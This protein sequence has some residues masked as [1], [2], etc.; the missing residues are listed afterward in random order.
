[1]PCYHPLKGYRA[2]TL[3]P[4]G[5]RNITFNPKEAFTDW[6]INIPCGN[7]VGCRLERSRQW[8]VRIMHEAQ[9]HEANSFITLTYADENRPANGTLEVKDFQD[10][11]KRLRKQVEPRKIRFFH[12]GEYGEQTQRPH[13]HACLFG[14]NFPD[15]KPWKKVNGHQYYTSQ[16]LGEVWTAGNSI[17]GEL[18][19][20]SA[21]Y[22]A[23]Y[24]MK[25]ATGPL[26]D[27]Y[28]TVEDEKTGELVKLKPEYVTMSRRPGIGKAWLEKFQ[29]DVFPHDFVLVK[30]KNRYVKC[31]PPKFYLGQFELSNPHDFKKLKIKREEEAE[32]K[33]HDNTH[34]RLMTKKYIKE[35]NATKLKRNYEN[36]D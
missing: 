8:A 35:I 33:A 2:R 25:K 11:M 3:N 15:Q 19:F 17:V 21:A 30:R 29:A 18:T 16:K 12:C 32:K 27:F 36:E 26:S 23:R 1:M 13:Y 34:E 24:I 28:Y 4:T 5:R 6:K 14:L 7:C 22:V 20:E 9:L 10:F 31:K